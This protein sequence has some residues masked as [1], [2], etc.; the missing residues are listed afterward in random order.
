M[1]TR[2]LAIIIIGILS[3]L[4]LSVLSSSIYDDVKTQEK[5]EIDVSDD[6][7]GEREW[8]WHGPTS[9][10]L[11][12]EISFSVSRMDVFC[13]DVFVAKIVNLDR[14]KTFWQESSKVEC[15]DIKG[16]KISS[17]DFPVEKPIEVDVP[18][19][20]YV[21]VDYADF[22][23]YSMLTKKINIKVLE[24][25]LVTVTISQGS[26]NASLMKTFEPREITVMLGVNSTVKWINQDE[27]GSAIITDSKYDGH[28]FASRYLYPGD[29]W[30]FTFTHPGIYE[31]H[32]N[33]HPWKT[34]KVIGLDE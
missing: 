19:T 8:N 28:G 23:G 12:D 24:D 7:F 4:I 21:I 29:S 30:Q 20:Y 17:A 27:V 31:Y 32:S 34:G 6:A 10:T 18:G 14:S 22:H 26:G 5:M 25:A 3:L 2:L 1:K 16:G 15:S 33:P 13:D 9:F 11:G